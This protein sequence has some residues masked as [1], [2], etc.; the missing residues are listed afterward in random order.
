[1]LPTLARIIVGVR[2]E[3]WKWRRG[4]KY[5]GIWTGPPPKLLTEHDLLCGDVFFCGGTSHGKLSRLIRNAS[6]G[7]YIHC[8]LYIGNGLVVDVD[9]KG[10]RET[11]IND[12]I[13]KYSYI[14][15]T[16]CPGNEH[17]KT[18]RKRILN[19]ARVSLA[20]GISGY[21]RLGAALS[22]FREL[23]DL[24]NLETLWKITSRAKRTQIPPSKQ[25][26]CSEFIIEAYV[27]CGYIPRDDPFLSAS[28]RTPSGLAEENIFHPLGYISKTGWD[29][30]G[31]DDHFIGGCAW[32]LSREGRERLAKQQLEMDASII[33]Q[34]IA[35]SSNRIVGDF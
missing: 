25:S 34:S 10:I 8:A 9:G 18:Q 32:V 26:F 16:R 35:K 20:G 14:A 27:A 11:L 4:R 23:F 24:K 29:G 12:F 6:S 5:H 2:L 7:S 31:R 13:K 33:N 17:S 19:F 28:R 22:P 1:M 15:V 30:I 3:K 21:N